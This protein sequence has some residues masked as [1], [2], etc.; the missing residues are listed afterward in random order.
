[1]FSRVTKTFRSNRHEKEPQVFAA[2][3]STALPTP[4]SIHESSQE[5][6]HVAQSP[7]KRDCVVS[8]T[9]TAVSLK[10]KLILVAHYRE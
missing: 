4:H 2:A 7:T 8:Q 3:P 9:P 1:M 10:P 6:N 5:A